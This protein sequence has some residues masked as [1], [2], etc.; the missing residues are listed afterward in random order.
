MKIQILGSG[1]RKCNELF[2][3]VQNTVEQNRIDCE[4][5]KVTDLETIV[6]MGAV[7]TPALAIDG[8]IVSAGKLLS[9]A[10]ILRLIPEKDAPCC[11][12]GKQS[13][14]LKRAVT[15]LLIVFVFGSVLY[16]IDREN[17]PAAAPAD[18]AAGLQ[19]H[20]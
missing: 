18:T 12:A 2:S 11:C 4:V 9:K 1:C 20:F 10:E 14:F 3:A 5:E 7:V 16:M 19:L 6:S 8:R 17:K 15:A 13:P